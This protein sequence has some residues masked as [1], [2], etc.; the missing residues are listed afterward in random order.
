MCVISLEETI[1]T[2]DTVPYRQC[3]EVRTVS[4]VTSN[5]DKITIAASAAI[6]GTIVVAVVIFIGESVNCQ[7]K[8]KICNFFFLAASRRRSRKLQQLHHQQQQQLHGM[9]H[10]LPVNGLPVNCQTIEP[11]AS[12]AAYSANKVKTQT[13][14]KTSTKLSCGHIDRIGTRCRRTARTVNDRAC[15]RWNSRR[16]RHLSTSCAII[17]ARRKARRA[18]SPTANRSTA[19]RITRAVI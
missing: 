17:T 13:K 19:T 4:S 11:I 7:K 12:L 14:K 10:A 18:R 2:P 8:N 1:V 15:T 5:M 6:C 9:K 3:R 16:S